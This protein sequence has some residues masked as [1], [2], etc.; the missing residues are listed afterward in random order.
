MISLA[1]EYA[2]DSHTNGYDAEMS[3]LKYA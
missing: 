3:S 1:S 2:V